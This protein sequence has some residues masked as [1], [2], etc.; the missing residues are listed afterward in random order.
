MG[1]PRYLG[2]KRK[3]SL[4]RG[5]RATDA[6]D[7]Q[8]KLGIL[9]VALNLQFVVNGL[10][11]PE[12]PIQLPTHQQ[13]GA[14]RN[15]SSLPTNLMRPVAREVAIRDEALCQRQTLPFILKLLC[16]SLY[17]GSS[18]G[19]ILLVSQRLSRQ[20]AGC[21]T[22]GVQRRQQT[23]ADAHRCN[24]KTIRQSWGKGQIVD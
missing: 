18:P 23:H 9:T 19:V 6:T 11:E 2:A 12:L 1:R 20:N 17:F 15:S 16:L 21:R 7:E 8:G 4:R 24:H 10:V 14:V 5:S 3:G 13:P 22:R